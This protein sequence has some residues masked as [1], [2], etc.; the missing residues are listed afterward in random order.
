MSSFSS[1]FW[2]LISLIHFISLTISIIIRINNKSPPL[3]SITF[4]VLFLSSFL[5]VCRTKEQ[6]AWFSWFQ[7]FRVF[8]AEKL[9]SFSFFCL[10]DLIISIC[11]P[12]QQ[13][14]TKSNICRLS[15]HIKSSILHSHKQQ[16]GK[17]WIYNLQYFSHWLNIQ[18]RT[19][20]NS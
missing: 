14:N 10:F 8:Q 6:L 3:H 18:S 4:V 5:F 2:L 15:V 11:L 12:T 20:L 13:H 9:F 1:S 7:H 16:A 17:Y 19:Y